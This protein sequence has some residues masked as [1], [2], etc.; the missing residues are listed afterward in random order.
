MSALARTRFWISHLAVLGIGV[1]AGL[2]SWPPDEVTAESTHSFESSEGTSSVRTTAIAPESPLLP[3]SH[4][5][6]AWESLKDGGLSWK[7]RLEIQEALLGEWSV[8]DLAAAIRAAFAEGPRF[9]DDLLKSCNPGI[10]ADPAAAWQLAAGRAFG[11]ESA[12]VR[13]H[14]M[15]LVAEQDPLKVFSVLGDVPA[16]ERIDAVENLAVVWGYDSTDPHVRDEIWT[17]L[18][19]LD[20]E[21]W[22]N[23]ALFSAGQIIGSER[24]PQELLS[25]LEAARSPAERRLLGAAFA[26][27]LYGQEDEEFA[28]EFGLIPVAMRAE[29]AAA[30]LIID[31]SGTRRILEFAKLALAEVHLDAFPPAADHPAFADFAEETNYPSV[32]PENGNDD[33]YNNDPGGLADW[34]LTLPDDPRVMGIFRIALQGAAKRGYSTIRAKVEVLPPGWQRDHGIAALV[35]SARK[36]GE[37][38]IVDGLIETIGDPEIRAEARV[39]YRHLTEEE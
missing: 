23:M 15:K 11:W 30:G 34:A 26:V 20:G 28:V 19:D 38:T 24:R 32:F 13:K 18:L 29:V 16:N 1:V 35:E 2:Q 21:P 33:D 27:S 3:A 36:A 37:M 9:Q 22:G 12:R 10:L 17:K 6:A 8:I 31:D 39:G 7:A 14:W 25:L 5:A 4:Y